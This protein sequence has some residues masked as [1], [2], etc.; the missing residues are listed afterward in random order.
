MYDNIIISEH[1]SS[2]TRPQK[3]SGN[4]LSTTSAPSEWPI[5]PHGYWF[6]DQ[7]IGR[8]FSHRVGRTLHAS[9]AMA[10]AT[11]MLA[12]RPRYLNRAAAVAEGHPDT[13]VHPL[14]VFDVVLGLS[15][16]DLSS[17]GGAFLGG[18]DVVFHGDVY[19]GDT[20]NAESIVVGAR[21]SSSRPDVGIVTWSTTGRNQQGDL[22]ISFQRTNLVKKRPAGRSETIELAGY[23]EDFRTGLQFRHAQSRTI[24]DLDLNGWSLVLM[25]AATP[26]FSET[27]GA[28]TAFG[29]RINFGGLSMSLV[30][31]IAS[32]DTATHAV[33]ELGLSGIRFDASVKVGDT[34]SA[35]TEV[36]SLE[37][38]HGGADVTFRH[39]GL[40]QRDEIVCRVDRTVRIAS[41]PAG[42]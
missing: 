26:H 25:N 2:R 3:G 29:G 42:A 12:F 32:R 30:L 28:A 13:P 40:N 34:L 17:V 35:A 8:S 21:E 39:F 24:T 4:T 20:V 33:R 27:A 38:T 15:V 9:E 31:G 23:A 11:Q 41:R 5:V 19:P 37:P 1:A 18:E 7:P 36:L 22:V 10:F 6:E 14:M 16:E